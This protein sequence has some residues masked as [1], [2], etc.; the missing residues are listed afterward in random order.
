MKQEPEWID[1]V[2]LIAMHALLQVAPKNAR[3][4]EIANE[5]YIQAEAMMDVREKFNSDGGNDV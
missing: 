1:I 3:V 4:E 2:A 5:A